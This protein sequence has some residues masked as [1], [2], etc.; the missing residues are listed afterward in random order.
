MD[1]EWLKKLPA[2]L[3]LEVSKRLLHDVT[4]LQDRVNQSP[5]NSSRPP[6]SRAPWEK[7]LTS[8]GFLSARRLMA[9]QGVPI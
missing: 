7:P 4:E 3:L 8:I 9:R 5:T 6:T 1:D 2:E